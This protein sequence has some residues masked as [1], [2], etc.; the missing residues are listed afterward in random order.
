MHA[1]AATF[2][3]SRL[4][5]LAL[6][7]AATLGGAFAQ[8]ALTVACDKPDGVYAT[9]QQAVFTVSRSDAA[10]TAP[11]ATVKILR[12]NREPVLTETIPGS[13]A[14][15]SIRFTPPADGWYHCTVTL[16]GGDEKKPA[17]STGVVFNPDAYVPSMPAPDDFDAFW[18]AQ[19]AKLAA[20]KAVPVVVPLTPEQKLVE[21][22]NPDHRAKIES[23]EKQGFTVSNVTIPCV[24]VRP[25]EG[26]FASPPPSGKERRPAILLFHAAGVDGGWCRASAVSALNYAQKF[27]ALVLDMNAHGMLN[28]QPQPYYDA[29]AK[30]ELLGYQSQGRDSREHFYFLGMFLRLMRGI[31]FLCTRPDWD[32]KHLVCIGISQGGAQTLAAAGLDPRVSAAVATVPGMCDITGLAAGKPAGWPGIGD[33]KLDD[34]KTKQALATVRYFD[35]VN[36]CARSKAETLVTVGFADTTCSAPGVFTAYNQLKPSKRIITVPDKGHHA[37]SSP[38]AALSEQYN[39]FVLE[40]TKDR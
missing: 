36:F 39:A 4:L 13:E 12:N 37:L 27:N 16:P 2:V 35:A 18:A 29:L 6:S 34:E 25:V 30:G 22:A 31:D 10:E 21:E 40:H 23:L 33:G 3:K 8:S 26:Y 17:A 11:V 7:L 1:P 24:D 19:K 20:E 9:G 28:G 32:G 15:H 38:T 5:V 14:T